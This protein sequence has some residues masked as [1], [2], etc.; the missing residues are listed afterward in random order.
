MDKYTLK[1]FFFDLGEEI[2]E[3]IKQDINKKPSFCL[4]IGT[5]LAIPDVRRLAER[6]ENCGSEI[7]V[8]DPNTIKLKIKN[9]HVPTKADAFVGR[10][11]H[12]EKSFCDIC[13][14]FIPKKAGQNYKQFRMFMVHHREEHNNP[15]EERTCNKC[16]KVFAV[17]RNLVRHQKNCQ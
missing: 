11:K 2:E 3:I 17:K 9:L 13:R 4:I 14:N 6:F 1:V 7:I 15:V 10:L 5:S 12:V 16:S 8:V